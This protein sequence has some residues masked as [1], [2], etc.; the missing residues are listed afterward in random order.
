[1]RTRQEIFDIAWNGAKGQNFKRSVFENDP[2]TCAYRGAHGR[3]CHIGHLIPDDRYEPR[4]EVL[5]CRVHTILHAAGI[6]QDDADFAR[7]LQ[8]GHDEAKTA[9][10][11]ERNLRAF[12]REHDLT[13]PGERP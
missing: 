1:M 13:I 5:G 11:V 3:K 9:G 4:F 2:D 10:G 6:S 12:A 8:I 7:S